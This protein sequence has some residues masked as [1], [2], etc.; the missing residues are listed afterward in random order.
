MTQI[1]IPARPFSRP[2]INQDVRRFIRNC[3]ICGNATTWRDKEGLTYA[4]ANTQ[5]HVVR[6]FTRRRN[7]PP[8]DEEGINSNVRGYRSI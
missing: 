2:G 4:P 5:L 3:D 6:N 7:R 1:S 8:S